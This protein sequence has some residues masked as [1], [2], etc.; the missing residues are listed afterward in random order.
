MANERRTARSM[1][2]NIDKA[3]PAITRFSRNLNLQYLNGKLDPCH[4]R[5][6]LLVTVQKTLLRKSKPNVLLTGVAGC[7]KTALAEG[8]AAVLTQRRLQ[9]LHACEE[10][11]K[12][13]KERLTQWEAAGSIGDSPVYVSPPKPALCDCVVYDLSLNSMVSGTR[14]RGDFEE[15]IRDVVEECRKNPEVILFIDE[16][17]CVLKAGASAE[18]NSGA[19]Q[20]LKPALA[21]GD[22]RI[23]GA[24]T[25][26]EKAAIMKDKAFARRFC[27]LQVPELQA[28]AALDTARHI[29]KHYCSYHSLTTDITADE[30]L[31]QI[32]YHLPGTV[33]PDNFIN[34]V[35]ETLAGAVFDG[36]SQ[37][38]RL[39]FYATLSRMT[40][41]IILAPDLP[42]AG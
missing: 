14:Y 21:R 27:E 34:V 3:C 41:R 15:R 20:L 5:D 33:F 26:E 38:S 12:A 7:G 23:I 1:Y 13:Q 29:L 25:T 32:R 11:L 18:D 2:Q 28:D 36:L 35:D 4:H 19:A 40:G 24:T 9:Y 16:F 30:L 22:I 10:A 6:S 42:L 31:A 17:H 8:L 37:A 39:S